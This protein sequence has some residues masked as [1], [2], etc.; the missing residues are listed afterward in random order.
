[1]VMAAAR[2]SNDMGLG[3]GGLDARSGLAIS[4]AEQP[5]RLRGKF[6]SPAVVLWSCH[7]N[8]TGLVTRSESDIT[9][10]LSN[11]LRAAFPPGDGLGTGRG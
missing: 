3:H 4:L 6:L 10:T 8:S 7:G 11:S 5:V 2:A 9:H 1:M